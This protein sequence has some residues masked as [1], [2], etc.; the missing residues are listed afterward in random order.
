MKRYTPTLINFGIAVLV[1]GLAIARVFLGYVPSS[2]PG[3]KAITAAS[4]P[5]SFWI[6]V[7]F[8]LLIAFIFFVLGIV[9]LL[10]RRKG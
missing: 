2:R 7:A 4:S 8:M 3:H 6:T 1:L 5:A 10:R 9:S